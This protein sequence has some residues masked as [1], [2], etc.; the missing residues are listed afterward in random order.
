M[1]KI[2]H[3]WELIIKDPRKLD[4]ILYQGE[5]KT[6]EQCR[7]VINETLNFPRPLSLG[8]VSQIRNRNAYKCKS[9]KITKQDYI[10]I[11]KVEHTHPVAPEN[12]PKSSPEPEPEQ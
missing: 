4:K 12:S 6:L 5:L 2:N 1:P 7:E 8:S 9:G 3:V 10:T 11:N